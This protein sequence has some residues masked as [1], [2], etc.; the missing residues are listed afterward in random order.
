LCFSMSYRLTMLVGA[1]AKIARFL[2]FRAARRRKWVV[3]EVALVGEMPP[4]R[5]DRGCAAATHYLCVG[6]PI[7]A[8]RHSRGS[9]DRSAPYWL[10][11]AWTEI[12]PCH[13]FE[14]Y[15][16]F[17]KR[18]RVIPVKNQFFVKTIVSSGTQICSTNSTSYH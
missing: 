1:A 6:S 12:V 10:S 9:L 14:G 15:L 4:T 17:P 3:R 16:P 2:S 5:P 8:C 11:E 18:R 7:S 13:D